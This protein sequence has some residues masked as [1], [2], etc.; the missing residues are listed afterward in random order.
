ME[1]LTIRSAFVAAQISVHEK[2]LKLQ[3]ELVLVLETTVKIKNAINETAQVRTYHENS[4]K[5]NEQD[6][7]NSFKGN[8]IP[9]RTTH[10]HREKDNTRDTTRKHRKESNLPEKRESMSRAGSDDEAQQ[11][12]D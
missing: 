12:T 11:S 6:T 10:K 5:R 1:L 4:E 9:K 8:S 7:L 2:K 3:N